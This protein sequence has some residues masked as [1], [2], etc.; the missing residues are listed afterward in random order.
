MR[1]SRLVGLVR[2]V[3]GG[4]VQK[5]YSPLVINWLDVGSVKNFVMEWNTKFPVDRWW[6]EKHGIAFNSV[7]HRE[8][9]IV[10]M[11]FE[12]EE[13][14]LYDKI[15]N[16]QV[17]EVNQ[18]NFFK[19]GGVVDERDSLKEFLEEERNFDYGQYNDGR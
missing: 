10:D 18:G 8:V 14:I 9:S 13:D 3:T 6:R 1:V 11:R 15:L 16:K 19:E 2:K 4:D 12:W 17:Y 7:Q 5:K